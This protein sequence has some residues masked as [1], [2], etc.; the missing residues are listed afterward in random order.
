[1]SYQDMD[2]ISGSTDYVYRRIPKCVACFSAL[3]PL[4]KLHCGHSFCRTCLRALIQLGLRNRIEG[5]PRCCEYPL[6][7]ADVAWADPDNLDKF[8]TFRRELD[9]D[10]L[11]YCC[12]APCSA[13]LGPGTVRYLG[14]GDADRVRVCGKCRMVNCAACGR[15]YHP[16]AP[17]P[18]PNDDMAA[19]REIP[20][21]DQWRRCKR[22]G[23]V[24]DR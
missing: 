21:A 3:V 10:A 22:C 8:R 14:S 6:K 7:E 15:A 9:A 16:E 4:Q 23:R 19:F 11:F 20:G 17:C 12:Y 2:T 1:M 24:I 18:D 13:L 5:L